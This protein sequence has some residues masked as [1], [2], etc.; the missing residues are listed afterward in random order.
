ML[1]AG[2]RAEPRWGFRSCPGHNVDYK[3]PLT[4]FRLFLDIPHPGLGLSHQPPSQ[5]QCSPLI[6]SV[7]CIFPKSSFLHAI[8]PHP[9]LSWTTVE[10]DLKA[11]SSTW[12]HRPLPDW[13]YPA[14]LLAAPAPMMTTPLPGLGTSSS[15][16]ILPCLFHFHHCS[17]Y[18]IHLLLEAHSD[19]LWY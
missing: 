15:T 12:H 10:A 4:D 7:W 18:E 5:S 14:C 9:P 2:T 19:G 13:V 11:R 16:L 17:F 3:S 8:S 1:L 6:A